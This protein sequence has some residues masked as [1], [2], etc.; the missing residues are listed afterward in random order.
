MSTGKSENTYL[1]IVKDQ[2]PGEHPT[3]RKSQSAIDNPF[4]RKRRT[5]PP[6]EPANG[7]ISPT[8]TIPEEIETKEGNPEPINNPISPTKALP[9]GVGTIEE[10][11]KPVNRPILSTRT[12][13]T[14]GTKNGNSKPGAKGASN[15]NLDHN[16][17][18]VKT[19][20]GYPRRNCCF[21]ASYPRIGYKFRQHD[22]NNNVDRAVHPQKVPTWPDF[23]PKLND[24]APQHNSALDGF[25]SVAQESGYHQI[26]ADYG[27]ILSGFPEVKCHREVTNT[28]DKKPGILKE[29]K[30]KSSPAQ[31]T[32]KIYE[33]EDPEIFKKKENWS[34]EFQSPKQ[35]I[36]NKEIL[37][38]IQFLNN[39]PTTTL[40]RG[41]ET[42]EENSEPVN[43]PILPTKTP[44]AKVEIKDKKSEPGAKGVPNFQLDHN[45]Q[46]VRTSSGHPRCNYC[47]IASHTRASCKIRQHDLNNNVDRAVHPRRGWLSYKVLKGNPEVKWDREQSRFQKTPSKKP[48]I[49][50]R[51]KLKSSPTQETQKIYEKEDPQIFKEKE[52]LPEE[53]QSPKQRRISNKEMSKIIQF[54]DNDNK[55]SKPGAKR[56]SNFRLDDNDQMVRASSSHP[57]DLNNNVDLKGLLD[58]KGV[59]NFHL[60]DNDQVIITSPGHPRCNYC[61]ATS[62]PRVS[63]KIRQHDLNN[64]IDRTVHPLKGLLDEKGVSNFHLDDNNRVII[65]SQGHLRCNYCFAASHPRVSCKIRQHDLNNNADHTVHPLKELLKA[66]H[67]SPTDPSSPTTTLPRGVGTIDE[68]S[69]H[70]NRPI[71]PTRTLATE[72]GIKNENSE[73][74]F[75]PDG[76]K[77]RSIIEATKFWKASMKIET[78]KISRKKKT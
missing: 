33:N 66:N 34:G 48:G 38:I 36:S 9:G 21:I 49:L 4:R 5:A 47:L 14:V 51:T 12:L 35:R 28:P 67:T 1:T 19:S 18:I 58:E 11:L 52:N 29:T 72:V 57:H 42:I 3:I 31:K 54:L 59:S 68:N 30:L 37:K 44:A 27:N 61:F 39:D 65:T 7:P 17:Q 73:S 77:F 64:N 15:F 71:L 69:E 75:S 76:K 23:T 40:P 2:I 63:C 60:D 46:M 22:L 32:P 74:V 10:N 43:R 55:N 41:V 24:L 78:Q 16:D 45:G 13:E 56:V 6:I 53:F 50:K 70:V 20:S 8:R 26:N 62:H 25:G